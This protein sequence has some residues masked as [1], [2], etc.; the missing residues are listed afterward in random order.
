MGK[1]PRMSNFRQIEGK[2]TDCSAGGK[3]GTGGLVGPQAPKKAG[4]KKLPR[5]DH[6]A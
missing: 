3:V 6:Q 2:K 4:E 5:R 1:K